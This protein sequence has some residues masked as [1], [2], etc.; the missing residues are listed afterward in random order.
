MQLS[1]ILVMTLASAILA[2]ETISANVFRVEVL[3]VGNINL[4]VLG[5]IPLIGPA[6][7]L[8]VKEIQQ[9]YS[10]VFNLSHTYL[11]DR[12]ALTCLDVDTV[13][14]DLLARHF[15][16]REA[17]I[18]M[19]VIITPGCTASILQNARLAQGRTNTSRRV[20]TLFLLIK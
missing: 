5:A 16:R 12:S 17:D 8:A 7:D 4:E 11:Y 19:T 18:N 2:A 3:T 9:A 1:T 10:S 15:Y 6:V 14:D 13:S 20:N